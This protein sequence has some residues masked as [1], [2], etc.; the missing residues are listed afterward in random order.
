MKK[1]KRLT[2]K[3]VDE[4]LEKS[5]DF[6]LILKQQVRQVKWLYNN[7]NKCTMVYDEKLVRIMIHRLQERIKFLENQREEYGI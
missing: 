5:T 2:I 7:A 3:Q 1:E 4:I 6:S